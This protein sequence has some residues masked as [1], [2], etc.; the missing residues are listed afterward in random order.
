MTHMGIN[1]SYIINYPK[2]LK[3]RY[4]FAR[5]AGFLYFYTKALKRYY[6]RCSIFLVAFGIL[7]SAGSSLGLRG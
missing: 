4:H 1:S 7:K 3:I 6:T 2:R 5:F